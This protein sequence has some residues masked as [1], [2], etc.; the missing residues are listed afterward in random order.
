MK[1]IIY[2]ISS[3]IVCVGMLTACV[4]ET[5]SNNE[6]IEMPYASADYI[7]SEWTLESLTEHFKE[8]GFSS[9]ENVPCEPSEDNYENNIFE[10]EI[11]TGWASE[12]P[13]EAGESFNS[14]DKIMIYYNKYPLLTVENCPDLVTVLT[15]NDMDYMSFVEKYDGRYVEFDASVIEHL[16]YNGEIDHIINVAGDLNGLPIR[17]GN[18]TWGCSINESAQEGDLVIVSGRIDKSQSEYFKMLYVE[19][20]YMNKK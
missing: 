19:T 17:I 1:K 2:L 9:F 5:T 10:L 7:S 16:T 20:L 12:D 18:L 14:D 6:K 11:C 13:W 15:S 3:F 4:S 8:M